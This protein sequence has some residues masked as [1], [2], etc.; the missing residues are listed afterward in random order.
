ML[1]IFINSCENIF[2]KIVKDLRHELIYKIS[3]N[4]DEYQFNLF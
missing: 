1:L 4:K 2:K 3:S